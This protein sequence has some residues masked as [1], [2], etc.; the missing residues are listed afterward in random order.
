MG[1]LSKLF[2]RKKP[3]PYEQYHRLVI[4]YAHDAKTLE[5][6]IGVH[7]TGPLGT[8]ETRADG[9]AELSSAD[10]QLAVVAELDGY[11]P[12]RLEVDLN[13]GPEVVFQLEPAIPVST[14]P[15]AHLR[16]RFVIRLPFVNPFIALGTSSAKPD[17]FFM[18]E[19]D[20]LW[21]LDRAAA[22]RVL[23]H[24]KSLGYNHVPVGPVIEYGYSG[25]VP[26]TDWRDA[27]DLFA[28][29]IVWL[30][31]DNA[32]AYT[33][34]VFPNM[35]PWWKGGNRGWD[36]QKIEAEF[37]AIYT[38]PIVRALTRNVAFCWEE[39]TYI[40]GM[41]EGFRLLVKWFPDAERSFH[42]PPG[43][44]GPGDGSESE[45]DS[46]RKCAD[47]GM[48]TLDVQTR[49]WTDLENFDQLG[50]RNHDGRTPFEQAAYDVNDMQRR[51]VGAPDSPWRDRGPIIARDGKPIRIRYMEGLSFEDYWTDP[52]YDR[53][54]EYRA[55]MLSI[56]GVTDVLD[57]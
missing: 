10:A 19:L 25:Q 43:H 54:T 14:A 9:R 44:L 3:A 32:M 6:L 12:Q 47:A 27:P 37:A 22:Q 55:A 29:Y 52:P 13:T 49:P 4:V 2:G 21:R 56:N 1:W 53:G 39:Y 38:Q 48:T 5:P 46:Q 30:C 31:V 33:L 15:E 51:A 50:V 17:R 45:E 34:F 20:S 26:D 57:A 35:A 23:D 8:A 24:Y 42:T 36:F 40:A 18:S 41:C 7:I 11:T 28:E 16:G